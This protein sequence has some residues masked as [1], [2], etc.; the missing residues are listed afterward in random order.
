[1][2]CR[3]VVDC[4]GDRVDRELSD[5]READVTRHLARCQNCRGFVAQYLMTIAAARAA[6]ATTSDDVRRRRGSSRQ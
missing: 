5:E 1:M 6:Y 4:L 2:T 3:E